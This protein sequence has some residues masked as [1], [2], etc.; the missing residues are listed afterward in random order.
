[1][2]V[3]ESTKWIDLEI[4]KKINVNKRKFSA[5]E[6]Y[7]YSLN[8]LSYLPITIQFFVIMVAFPGHILEITQGINRK[9]GL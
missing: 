7:S 6:P 1:M 9:L 4:G 3:L 8:V 5:Q 2:P